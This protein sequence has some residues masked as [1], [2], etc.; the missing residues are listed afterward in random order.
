MDSTF[1]TKPSLVGSLGSVL[2]QPISSLLWEQINDKMSYMRIKEGGPKLHTST[3][4][5]R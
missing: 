2:F 4:V 3:L 1:K 5:R